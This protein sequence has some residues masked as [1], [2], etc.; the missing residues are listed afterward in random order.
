MFLFLSLVNALPPWS[1]D[2]VQ[3]YVHCANFSGEWNDEA[4]AVL[5]KQ[6]FVVFEKYHK[7]FQEPKIDNAEEK[8]TESCRKVKALNPKT[9]CYIYVESDWARTEYSLGHWFEDNPSAQLSCSAGTN[10]TLCD[11]ADKHCQQEGC[12]QY[13]LH[14]SAYDFNNSI[15]REKWIE[16]VTNVTATGFVDGAFIDGDRNGW[17][18]SVTSACPA[19]KKAGWAAGL[20]EAVETLARRLG[21]NKTLIS[22]YPTSDAMKF[23][24][25]GMMERGGSSQNIESFGKKTCGLWNQSCLLD[26]HAQYFSKPAD[27]KLAS[28]LLGVQKYGYFGGGSGWGGVGSD[29][30]KLWLTEFPEFSKKLGEPVS[31]MQGTKAPWAGAVCDTS[32]GKRANTSGCMFT[33]SFASGTKVFVGQYLQPA[34][35]NDGNCI[36]W[37][38]G[39]V[40]TD[41]ATRCQPKS[42]F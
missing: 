8:I 36:Y 9:D 34:G 6:P 40:T 4:L 42:E 28:F 11:C 37:S 18:S 20:G 31:D 41:N 21:K 22:N 7:V 30:C 33:R 23:C 29:A 19:E 3:T 1:W 5:A 16:R 14:Y 26:Y 27:G 35:R 24:V 38:D 15:A 32:S 2:T 12:K 25:G 17:G 39:S 13:N 10:D